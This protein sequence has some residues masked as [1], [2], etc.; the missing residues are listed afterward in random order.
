[1]RASDMDCYHAGQSFISVHIVITAR[2]SV[3]IFCHKYGLVRTVRPTLYWEHIPYFSEQQGVK[4]ME[5][6][7]KP[8]VNRQLHEPCRLDRPNLCHTVGR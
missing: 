2:S 6:S 5:M 4:L 8:A 3:G 7:R 1:M